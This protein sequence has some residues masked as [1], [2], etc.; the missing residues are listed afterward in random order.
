MLKG[1]AIRVV[2]NDVFYAR[3]GVHTTSPQYSATIPPHIFG[4][5]L[6]GRNSSS[7]PQRLPIPQVS[8]S[9]GWAARANLKHWPSLILPADVGTGFE[10]FELI[11]GLSS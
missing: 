8:Q 2:L 1:E 3:R 11:V 10:L 9:S 4:E 5:Q 6:G 7:F